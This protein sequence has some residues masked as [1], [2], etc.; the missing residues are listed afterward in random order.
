V[1]IFASVIFSSS[2]FFQ[3]AR[4]YSASF[5]KWD[6]RGQIMKGNEIMKEI[7]VDELIDG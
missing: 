3:T 5:T 6:Y 7:T 4:N 1:M 2:F